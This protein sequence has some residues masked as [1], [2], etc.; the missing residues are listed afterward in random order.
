MLSAH[1]AERIYE[2]MK[3][4]AEVYGVK[5]IAFQDDVFT[6]NQENVKRLCN[7]LIEY[8]LDI[9]WHCFARVDIVSPEL[10]QLMKKAGCWQVMYGVENFSQE[11]LN[12]MSKGLDRSQIFDGVRW[13][14]EAGIEVRICM[15]V[16]NPGDTEEIINNNIEIVKQLDP[17][18]LSNSILTPFPGHAIYNWALKENRIL[19]FDWDLYYG[20]TPLVQIDN[21]SPDDLKRLSRKMTFEVYFR[22]KFILKKIL[23]LRTMTELKIYTKGFMGLMH[24]Y[25]EKIIYSF[26]PRKKVDKTKLERSYNDLTPEEVQHRI[27]LTKTATKQTAKT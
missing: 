3:L 20:A 5:D 1:S 11:I 15:M 22:P 8:P 9:N 2:E 10:L 6:V 13:A 18:F 19:S 21:L 14:K 24:F 17:D 16:G 12:G 25:L 23:S 27:D 26:K 7:L 4:L